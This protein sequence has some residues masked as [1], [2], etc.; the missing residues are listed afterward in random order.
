MSGRSDAKTSP[1]RTGHGGAPDE[2][3]EHGDEIPF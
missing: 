3:W 2:F 1:K